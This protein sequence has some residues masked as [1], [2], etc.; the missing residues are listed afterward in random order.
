MFVKALPE[1]NVTGFY[2][3]C[4]HGCIS[5]FICAKVWFKDIFPKCGFG[6]VTCLPWHIWSFPQSAE[7]MSSIL[8][9]GIEASFP[10][11]PQTLDEKVH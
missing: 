10:S 1:N 11:I 9:F 4:S 2:I 6:C 7:M 8:L 5:E 3:Q